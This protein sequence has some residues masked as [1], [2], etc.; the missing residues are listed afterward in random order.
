MES[1]E[2]HAHRLQE[3]LEVRLSRITE[4]ALDPTD[5]RARQACLLSEFSL[6]Q[7]AGLA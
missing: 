1:G 7:S 4:P 6:R 5:L 3:T 2:G